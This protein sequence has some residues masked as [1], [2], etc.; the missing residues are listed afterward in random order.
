VRP[1]LAITREEILAY[2]LENGLVWREDES[3]ATVD[4]D[5]NRVRHRLLPVL[6]EYFGEA[7]IRNVARS[8]EYLEGYYR[9]T[10]EPD[11]QARFALCSTDSEEPPSLS[12]EALSQ[13][14]EVWKSRL[15]LEALHR[16]MPDAPYTATQALAIRQL[17][18]AQVGRKVLLEVGK[19]W[20]ERERLVFKCAAPENREE[21]RSLD[22]YPGDRFSTPEGVLTVAAESYLPDL[23]LD[24]GPDRV[25]LDAAKIA[26]PLQV[27]RWQ[28][29][30]RLEPLGMRG[31]KKV[32]DLLT[33]ERISQTNLGGD[34][35]NR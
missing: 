1:L 19:V 21:P 29:G 34:L 3:N 33:D 24:A 25:L 5:R 9:H 4:Y 30:D 11:L 16:W 27:R 14:P 31:H 7:S 15:I 6:R 2:A 17:L 20:R 23:P 32:S 28:S 12:I 35:H 22:L 26:F 10:I 13:Q 8:A 18:E